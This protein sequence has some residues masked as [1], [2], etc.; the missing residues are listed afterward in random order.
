[1]RPLS[2]YFLLKTT[3]ST[4]SQNTLNIGVTFCLAKDK[5]KN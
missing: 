5:S 2:F 4:T 1:M 3:I